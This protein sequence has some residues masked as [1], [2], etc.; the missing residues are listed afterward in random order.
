MKQLYFSFSRYLKGIFGERL[1]RISINAGFGC[2][3]LDGK[4][5]S[6]GCIYCN[7]KAFGT[8]ARF[9]KSIEEQIQESISFYK[10]RYK[11]KKFIAYF[12]SY[13]N[14]Y[15]PPKVLKERFDRIKQFKEIS[16]LFIATRPDC[17]DEEKIK[18]IQTYQDKYLVWIEYGLQTTFDN[19]LKAINR[20][21]TYQDFLKALSL[22]RR[23]K[24]NTGVHMILGLPGQSRDM[25]REDA[26]RIAALDIQGVK[27]HLLHVLKDT[28]LEKLYREGKVTLLDEADYVAWLVDFLELIPPQMVIM[29]LNSTAHRDYLVAPKWINDK[30]RVISLIENELKRRKSFQGKYYKL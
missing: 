17:V 26:R 18:L 12:Q 4:L 7:N 9:P 30:I 14:T 28:P 24:I 13:T 27:F 1:Q 3:N 10:T 15:A 5:S 8:Y 16:G 2:P 23:F 21:H 25:A 6:S 22:T 29:R 11:V 19:I 20:N